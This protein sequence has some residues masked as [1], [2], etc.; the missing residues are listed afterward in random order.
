MTLDKTFYCLDS[1]DYDSC[2]CEVPCFQTRYSVEVS[3]SKFPDAGTAETLA[4]YYGDINYQ[5]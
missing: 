2:G 1:I 3:F 4:S 5:R